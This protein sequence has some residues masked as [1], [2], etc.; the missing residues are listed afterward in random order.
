MHPLSVPMTDIVTISDTILGSGSQAEV[1][2]GYMYENKIKNAFD[3]TIDVEKQGASKKVALK[4]I[5]KKNLLSDMN[6]IKHLINEIKVV[7]TTHHPNIIGFY[8][9]FIEQHDIILVFEYAAKGDLYTLVTTKFLTSD[10]ISTIFMDMVRSIE[11]LHLRN[12]IHRDIKLENFLVCDGYKVKLADFGFC[13]DKVENLSTPC[14]S[15]IY[16]APEIILGKQYDKSVDLWAL[17]VCL[18]SLLTMKSPWKHT[19]MRDTRMDIVNRKLVDYPSG[20]SELGKDLID[21]LIVL[22][23]KERLTAHETLFHGFIFPFNIFPC[24]IEQTPLI[25]RRISRLPSIVVRKLSNE[26]DDCDDEKRKMPR[27]PYKNANNTLSI[28]GRRLLNLIESNSD[29]ESEDEKKKLNRSSRSLSL[30]GK[31]LLNLVDPQYQTK[32]KINGFPI[33]DEECD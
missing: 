3:N 25:Q 1:R 6:T 29:F 11:Y 15:I 4:I 10:Q 5:K 2:L 17:G 20:I 33:I 23:P 28:S 12:V 16:A 27:S 18:F 7:S 22:E 13:K 19:T 14:G 21:K 9:F 24:N 31:K 32:Q 26:S 8:G 30:S